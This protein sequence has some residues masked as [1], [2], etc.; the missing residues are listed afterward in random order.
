MVGFEIGRQQSSLFLRLQDCLA[1]S[2]PFALSIERWDP[3]GSLSKV[4]TRTVREAH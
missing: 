2:E 3:L 1:S 4:G